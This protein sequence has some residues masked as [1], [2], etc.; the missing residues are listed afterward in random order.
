MANDV[1]KD[2]PAINN[3][4]AEDVENQVYETANDATIFYIKKGDSEQS[5]LKT[6]KP[7]LEHKKDS[8]KQ[9]GD[10][11]NSWNYAIP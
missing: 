5:Q 2:K 3:S 11:V 8:L 10:K 9:S 4:N 1:N 7:K 6:T